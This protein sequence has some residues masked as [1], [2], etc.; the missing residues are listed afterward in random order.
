V[1]SRDFC[2]LAGELYG[3]GDEVPAERDRIEAL[4]AA[5]RS[6]AARQAWRARLGDYPPPGIAARAGETEVTVTALE[7]SCPCCGK[8][9]AV[10]MRQGIL[11]LALESPGIPR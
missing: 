1:C 6:Q 4:A 3:A 5:A 7:A 10:L 9:V 11:L 8:P 2:R